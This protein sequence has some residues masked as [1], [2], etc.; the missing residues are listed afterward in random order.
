MDIAFTLACSWISGLVPLRRALA[1]VIGCCLAWMVTVTWAAAPGGGQVIT[2]SQAEIV[3]D[4]GTLT[5]PPDSAAW[6]SVPLPHI[7]K[8]THP[9]FEGTMWYRFRVDVD[10]VPTQPWAVYIP[11]VV[12]NAQV[13][14]NGLPQASTGSMVYPVTRNWYV[15]LI[16]EIQPS[17]MK[18]GRNDIYIRVATGFV[19]RAGLSQVQV[20]PEALLHGPYAARLWLQLEGTDVVSII[21][22]ALGFVML[23]VWVR[24]RAQ[25]DMGYMGM[26]SVAWALHAMS[27]IAPSPWFDVRIWKDISYVLS[28]VACMAIS[29]FIFRFTGPAKPW[30]DR[31]IL[32]FMVVASAGGVLLQSH[33]FNISCYAGVGVI[34][35]YATA[36]GTWRVIRTKRQDGYWLVLGVAVTMLAGAHDVM[37]MFGMLPFEAIFSVYYAV[38][39]LVGCIS[40]ILTGEYARTRSAL[41]ELNRTLAERVSER[42]RALRESFERLAA[43]ERARAVSDERSRILKDMHD[44]VGT[45]LTSA[46]RQLQ[47][48]S[49]DTVDVPLVAQTLRDSL[50]QLKL[51]IDALSLVPGDIAGLL[52]SWRFRLAPRLKAAGIELVWDVEALPSWPDGQPPSLRN[53]QYILFEG[54]SNVLQHAHA[55]RLVLSARDLGH[56]IR[57]SLIDNGTGWRRSGVHEGQGLQTMRGRALAIG[58]RMEFLPAAHGGLELRLSLPI[59]DQVEHIDISSA[60]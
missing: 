27:E 59:S 29:L 45:H 38:P 56:T 46:L 33:L 2:L 1:W 47:G 17:L 54:L 24:D 18:V 48:Q 40:V 21:V 50:D 39:F 31:V 28:I 6:R 51:S 8:S 60:A 34:W 13:W 52:A 20:G 58:A 23:L 4:Q 15:P 3:T 41:N 10:A 30:R 57:I 22:L 26:S 11:R 7:W 44:G 16:T 25:V 9:D 49:G 32:A 53:L 37:G 43:L 55:T 19:T 5:P 36:Y 42:E 14:I 12:T 35:A